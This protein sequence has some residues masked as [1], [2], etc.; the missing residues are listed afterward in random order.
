MKRRYG[1][2]LCTSP[3]LIAFTVPTVG[4]AMLTSAGVSAAAQETKAQDA[5]PVVPPSLAP[6]APRIADIVVIGNKTLSSAY[7]IAASGHKVGD[8]CTDQT[9]AEMK[10]NLFQTGNF[11]WHSADVE[12]AVRVRSE[13]PNPPNGQCKVVIEVDENDTIK[14][15]NITGSGPVKVTEIRALLHITENKSVYNPNQFL[16]DTADIQDL[17]SRRGYIA[18]FGADAGPDANS[19]SIL[20]VPIV[21]T[22]VAKI[23]VAKNHKTRR[24][25][26]LREMKTKEGDYF[27]RVTFNNDLRRLYNLDLFEE[28][29][30]A[31]QV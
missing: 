13:E 21:V 31:E 14:G 3:F 7:I 9:I 2:A 25:V 6:G 20:N 11:G 24:H 10:T 17:F 12:E 19:P 27:N 4:M 18:T 26:I 8:T 22:R 30:P 1:R 5:K 28:V 15:V 23:D 16:R 29:T